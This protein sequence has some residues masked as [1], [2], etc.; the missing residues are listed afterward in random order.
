MNS[1][2]DNFGFRQKEKKL[3]NWSRDVKFNLGN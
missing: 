3:C 2:N 1:K